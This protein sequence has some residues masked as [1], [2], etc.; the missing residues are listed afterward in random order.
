MDSSIQ[1]LAQL[2]HGHSAAACFG[3]EAQLAQLHQLHQA[4]LPVCTCIYGAPGI[5]KTCL[6]EHFVSQCQDEPVRF[7]I[8]DANGFKP[9]AAELE[10]QLATELKCTAQTVFATLASQTQ[11]TILIIDNYQAM[12]LLDN[13]LRDCFLS[14]LPANVRLLLLSQCRPSSTWT[15]RSPWQETCQVIELGPLSTDETQSYFAAKGYTQ[16]Q[17]R[18]LT[19]LTQGLPIAIKLASDTLTPGGEGEFNQRQ[20]N[21]L[22]IE[23]A[24]VYLESMPEAELGHQG[25]A[26][27][28]KLLSPLR[29]I[30]TEVL[31]AMFPEQSSARLYQR[32]KTLPFVSESSDGL[33]IQASVQAALL[34]SL[35]AESNKTV[36]AIKRKAWAMLASEL[37]S[38]HQHNL[39]RFTA[40]TIY[41]LSSPIIREAFFPEQLP[42]FDVVDAKADQGE[43]V[44]AIAERHESSAA[45]AITRRWWQLMPQAFRLVLNQNGEV[46]GYY[47]AIASDALPTGLSQSDP[48]LRA[49]QHHLK[50]QRLSRTQNALFIRRWLANDEGDAPSVVQA[51]AWLD[52]KRTYLEMWPSLRLVYLAVNDLAPY[53]QTAGFLGFT[54]HTELSSSL[55][56]QSYHGAV[57]D[58]GPASVRGWLHGLLTKELGLQPDQLL[59]AAHQCLLVDGESIPLTGL[60]FK[61]VSLLSSQI[62]QAVSREYLLKVVWG[63]EY[64]T[65]SNVVDAIITN[66]RRKMANQA[67]R[68]ETVRGMGYRLT[69]A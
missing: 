16:T 60:E 2:I 10:A 11:R 40:D 24:Q 26:H 23:L 59:D 47:L 28:L 37:K 55:G 31:D 17:V 35:N 18:Q 42:F 25:L 30:T 5:G 67:H 21:N 44:L 9:T 13:W 20:S 41:L 22:L 36:Q 15:T 7:V 63:I 52:L 50:S 39:W 64:S 32:L 54:P 61:V 8:L 65:S 62:G 43:Q 46:A 57:L 3:R 69:Q 6:M 29:R 14:H 12:R 4:A 34:A 68:I 49:W 1:T 51:A 45:L 58:M 53:A 19:E 33:Q 66:L 48:L 56:E 27:K 38:S